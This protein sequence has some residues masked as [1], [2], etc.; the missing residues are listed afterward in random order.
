[1]CFYA[2]PVPGN[3]FPAVSYYLPP[4]ITYGAQ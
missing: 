2:I 3:R 4:T 1:M